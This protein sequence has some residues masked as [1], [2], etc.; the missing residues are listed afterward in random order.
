[1]DNEFY[2]AD[3]S[4]VWTAA[5]MHAAVQRAIKSKDA[6]PCVTY[7]SPF[8][9]QAKWFLAAESITS[10]IRRCKR[11]VYFKI[12]T[13]NKL[14][15]EGICTKDEEYGKMWP[16]HEDFEIRCKYYACKDNFVDKYPITRVNDKED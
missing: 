14:F 11:C 10:P 9:I 5:E 6:A 12:I 3:E 15:T 7:E 16:F 13:K 1:M 8:Y 4:R 2:I